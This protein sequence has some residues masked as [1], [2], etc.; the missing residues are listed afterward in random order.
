MS[1][2]CTCR[3]LRV[4]RAV[5]HVP[6]ISR[7]AVQGVLVRFFRNGDAHHAGVSVAINE[8]ELKS[9][10]AFLNYLN[11]Q[12]KKLS[13][14]NGGIKHVYS[15]TGREIRSIS[16]F[17]ARQSYVA[18][19]GAFIKT[20]YVHSNDA[21]SDEPE[22]LTRWRSPPSNTEQIFL[23]PY[24]RMNIYESLFFNRNL[25]DT[26]DQWLNGQV[27]EL[28]ARFIGQ[29]KIAHLY[30]ITK[31]AFTEVRERRREVTKNDRLGLGEEFLA[32]IQ[33]AQGHGHVHRM[34]RRRIRTFATLSHHGST[35]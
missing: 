19:S 21:L 31:F 25:F 29:Q 9:W 6:S 27:T 24:S 8:L 23:L 10:E 22:S 4:A 30:A 18:A 33:H 34:Y 2:S 35:Q 17:Q 12:Q 32:V 5:V 1:L 16:K 13:P 14:A 26:F 7:R 20:I 11:H 28:L 15:L 3:C